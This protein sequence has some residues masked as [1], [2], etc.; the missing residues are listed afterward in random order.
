[1]CAGRSTVPP[2]GRGPLVEA[3]D[4]VAWQGLASV[5]IPGFVINRVVAVVGRISPAHMLH[6][7][8]TAAGLA[9]IPF[10]IRPI[11]MGVDHLMDALVRPLYGEGK[12]SD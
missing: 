10:I 6:W 4:T 12:K 7:A 3:A 9:A 5:A 8:P 11:D 1:V 2:P